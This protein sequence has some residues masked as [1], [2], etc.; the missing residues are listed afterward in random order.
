LELAAL[1]DSLAAKEDYGACGRYFL[2]LKALVRNIVTICVSN[3][4]SDILKH[5][6][7][8]NDRNIIDYLISVMY[9]S[10]I[11]AFCNCDQHIG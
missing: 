2:N 3:R 6:S 4:I 10:M 7:Y 1:S 9:F 11:V 8:L 5:I